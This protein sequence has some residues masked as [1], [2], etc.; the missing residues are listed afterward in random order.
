MVSENLVSA[1]QLPVNTFAIQS[2]SQSQSQA[3]GKEEK[4]NLNFQNFENKK[5]KIIRKNEKK[6]CFIFNIFEIFLVCFWFPV[7]V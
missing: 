5:I 4:I 2:Q 7:R 6:Y 3:L 1:R